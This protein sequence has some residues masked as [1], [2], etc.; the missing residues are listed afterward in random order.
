MNFYPSPLKFK[1][2]KFSCTLNFTGKSTHLQG[3]LLSIV[4]RNERINAVYVVDVTRHEQRIHGQTNDVQL[5][6]NV[7]V[8]AGVVLHA[9]GALFEIRQQ[10]VYKN[11]ENKF[12][13]NIQDA[14]EDH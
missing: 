4:K 1:L 8:R 11:Q 13:Q 6:A 14:F 10:P 9:T 7:G 2:E 12:V 3:C 5:E